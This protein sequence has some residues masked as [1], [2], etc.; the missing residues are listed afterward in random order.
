[1]PDIT[2]QPYL[3]IIELYKGIKVLDPIKIA[4]ENITVH[5]KNEYML[6]FQDYKK[7][8]T[9]GGTTKITIKGN[10][11][12]FNSHHMGEMVFYNLLTSDE[13]ACI[14]LTVD[15]IKC[16]A[17]VE[18]LQFSEECFATC[19]TEKNGSILLKACLKLLDTIKDR[20]K[21]KYVWLMDTSEKKCDKVND[22]IKLDS[23]YMLL[24]GN[25]WYGKYGFIPFKKVREVTDAIV[26]SKY[27]ENQRIVRETLIEDTKIGEILIKT[28]EQNELKINID[29]LKQ[30][31]VKNGKMT[32]CEFFKTLM[33]RFDQ[34]CELFYYS[35]EEIMYKC[36]IHDLH[37]NLYWLKL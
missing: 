35:Y 4:T 25:T 5:N 22:Y 9:G 17:H 2:K 18:S 16:V 27:E 32:I 20:Y 14:V 3:N 7:R 31:F 24:H 13:Q 1:M 36:G 33:K 26:K 6:N 19:A 8:Q 34:K 21:L 12:D 29:K 28:I 11:F 15:K 23:F 30:I 37:N 10:E